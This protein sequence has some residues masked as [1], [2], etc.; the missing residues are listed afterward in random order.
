[1]GC[2]RKLVLLSSAVFL[3]ARAALGIGLSETAASPAGPPPASIGDQMDRS[4][5][6]DLLDTGLTNQDAQEVT[7]SSFAGKA[8][9]LVPFLTS[10][11]EEC[12]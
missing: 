12:R 10:C 7:L 6:S 4:V 11:Q 5:P 2:R 1:M 9:L 8:V 3:L